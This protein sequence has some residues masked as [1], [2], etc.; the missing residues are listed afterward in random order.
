VTVSPGEVPS[1]AF[2]SPYGQLAGAERYLGL[3][4]DWI[5]PER[6]KAIVL[7]QEG[8]FVDRLRGQWREVTVIPTSPRLPGILRSA[9]RLRRMLASDPPDLVHANGVKAALVAVL[10]TAGTRTPVVWVKHDLSFDR[11]LARPLALGCRLVIGKSE[12]AARVFKG[13]LRRRVRVVLYGLPPVSADRAAARRLVLETLGAPESARIVGLIGRLY[14]MK[15]QHELLEILPDLVREVPEVR[16]AFVGQE[17]PSEAAYAAALRRRARELDLGDSL[18]F[19]GRVEEA[20]F[21]AAGCDLVA[22]PS[23]PAER[24]NTESF[25]LVAL[26]SMQVGTPVAGY[27]EGGLPE[28]VGSCGILVPTGDRRALLGTLVR[29]LRDDDLRARLAACGRERSASLFSLERMLSEL[30]AC[31]LEAARRGT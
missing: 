10:A 13:P 27:A 31:Y 2:V 7:L 19:V 18:T 5:P 22:T 23:V 17:D 3:V 21:F 8:P 6:I 16:V 15:G 26:E 14:P 24:G 4:L 30:R 9:W 12:A 28:V 1:V 25:S 11:S 29:A 20:P